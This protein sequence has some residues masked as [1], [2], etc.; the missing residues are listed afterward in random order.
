[1]LSKVGCKKIALKTLQKSLFLRNQY[2]FSNIVDFKLPDLGEKIKEAVVQ[3][4]HVVEG[5]EVEDFQ[6]VADVS[7]DKLFTS[8]PCTDNGII[9]KIFVQEGDACKVGGV[10]FQLELTS[11]SHGFKEPAEPV[12][13]NDGSASITSETASTKTVHSEDSPM[14]RIGE[15]YFAKI[16]A[17]PAVRGLAKELGVDIMKVV[18]TGKHGRILKEDVKNFRHTDTSQSTKTQPEVEAIPRTSTQKPS[19]PAAKLQAPPKIVVEPGQPTIYKFNQIEQGMVKS[20]NIST[21]VPHFY[22]FEE[23]DVTALV[24]YAIILRLSSE[25]RLMLDYQRNRGSRFLPSW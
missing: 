10:L 11:K 24:C 20:M 8:I 5:E 16:F 9:H 13:T 7:T 1:M 23:Y 14:T 2:F 12:S 18:G 3:K 17:T 15:D 4:W 22:L 21:T 6:N 19:T 25:R